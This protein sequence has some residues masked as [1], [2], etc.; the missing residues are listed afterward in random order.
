[1]RFARMVVMMSLMLTS[2]LGCSD[3]EQVSGPN[4]NIPESGLRYDVQPSWLPDGS[5]LVFFGSDSLT[6]PETYGIMLYSI[7]DSQ[8]VPLKLGIVSLDLE[9]TPD[10]NWVTAWTFDGVFNISMSGDSTYKLSLPEDATYP[11]WSPDGK[12]LAYATQSGSDRG[13]YVRDLASGQER[14]IQ[15][16]GVLAKWFPDCDKL[17][18]SSYGFG[19]AGD[20][21]LVIVDTSGALLVRLTNDDGGIGDIDVS[22]DGKSIIT[23][24]LG[25][26]IT[27]G[28]YVIS[29]ESGRMSFFTDEGT[30]NATI[31]PSGE[32]IA[33]TNSSSVGNGRLW[34]V[35]PDGSGRHQITFPRHPN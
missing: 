31:S 27:P 33:Y 25:G 14:K 15:P 18:M 4:D 17:A 10:G 29:V 9:V 34:L 3:D 28:I 20:E 8:T 26:G 2:T 1:M 16:Y 6:D 35:H 32:W 12:S 24:L 13:V 30:L 22:S 19:G 7:E 5:G 21:E 23:V 11:E